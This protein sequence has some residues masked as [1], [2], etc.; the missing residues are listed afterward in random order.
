MFSRNRLQSIPKFFYPLNNATPSPPGNPNSD[1]CA[2]Y[3]PIVGK[4]NCLFRFHYNP[5]QYLT[6]DVSLT[7]LL[8]KKYH[9]WA[10]EF[11]MICD[12]GLAFYCYPGA[13]DKRIKLK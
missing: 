2:K 3:D 4:A 6:I 13:N 7:F 9:K 5:H 11:W 8:N 10:V 1:L 12:A